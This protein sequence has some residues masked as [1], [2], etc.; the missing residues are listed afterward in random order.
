MSAPLTL[1]ADEMAAYPYRPGDEEH[2]LAR[3]HGRFWRAALKIADHP[4]AD[5]DESAFCS[6]FPDYV[7]YQPKARRAAA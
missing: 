6:L 3:N 1:T 4:H 5:D 7:P 2:P